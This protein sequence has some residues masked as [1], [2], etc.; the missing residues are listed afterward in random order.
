MTGDRPLLEVSELF[1]SY[2]IRSRV[3]GRVVERVRAVD[4]LSLAIR[5]GE[6]LGLVGESGCGK[7]TAAR[8]ILRLHQ[9]A[10]GSIRFDGQE[11]F[12]LSP[13]QLRPLRRRMQMIFQDPFGSLNPRMTVEEIVGEPF[14]IHRLARGRERARQ[15]AEL[16]E[17]MGLPREA[18]R[19]YPGELSGGERQRIGIAR[20]LAVRPEL[21][22]ADEPIS[23]LDVSVQAQV[24]NLLLDLQRELGLT[25]LFIAHDLSMVEHLST[26]VA[27]MYL[28]R[29]VEQAPVER[30]YRWPRHP[31]TQALLAAAPTPDPTR[32]QPRILLQGEPP[33]PLAPP[34]GCA[35]HPR[36]PLVIE[37]CRAGAPPLRD[38]GGEHQVSCWLAEGE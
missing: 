4:G 3:L 26:R 29:I 31:Y 32:R 12:G 14:T 21:V 16:L 19:R 33:S 17:R 34:P 10:R 24:A 25:F 5:R 36:C 23:A 28:G 13:A 30:L 8:A 18:M 20:S 6:T 38:L 35:F 2:P 37:R 15:V 11:L 9:P 22:V 27:V 1:A 7:S